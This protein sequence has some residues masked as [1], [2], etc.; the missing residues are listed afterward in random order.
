MHPLALLL[1]VA[2]AVF[3]IVV[4]VKAIAPA[5]PQ[6]LAFPPRPTVDMLTRM[7]AA[8]AHEHELQASALDDL[9]AMEL[10]NVEAA[11]GGDEGSRDA[12]GRLRVLDDDGDT[13][14]AG[15]WVDVGY[16]RSVAP[17]LADV[18][19]ANLQA[20]RHTI[21]RNRFVYR[22]SM[23]DGCGGGHVWVELG[24][25]DEVLRREGMRWLRHGAQVLVHDLPWTVYLQAGWRR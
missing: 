25:E 18:R 12:L 16:L 8:Y 14:A 2:A 3:I 6:P 13:G 22:A 4:S 10:V 17:S 9:T 24:A 15:P 7:K 11:W 5:A 1:L 20:A 21:E 19:L 23:C